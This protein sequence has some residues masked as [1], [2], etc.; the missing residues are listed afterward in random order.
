MERLGF[1]HISF[2]RRWGA[3]SLFVNRQIIAMSPAE[4]RYI[5]YALRPAR[6]IRRKL[7]G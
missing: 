6:L 7:F 2:S 4:Y 5:K 1:Y 3:D